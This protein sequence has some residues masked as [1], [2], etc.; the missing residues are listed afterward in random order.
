[1]ATLNPSHICDLQRQCWIL[2]PLSKARDRTHIFTETNQVLSPLSHNRS[3]N[4]LKYSFNKILKE[5]YITHKS[6]QIGGVEFHETAA[7]PH[8]CYLWNQH[9]DGELE[10][11]QNLGLLPHVSFQSLPPPSPSKGTISLTLIP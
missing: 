4:I 1:M 9:P 7:S 2:N 10:H 11:P 3:S 8:L 5:R 6:G